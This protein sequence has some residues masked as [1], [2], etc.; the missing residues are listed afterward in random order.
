MQGNAINFCFKKQKKLSIFIIIANIKQLIFFK[1][2]QP[3]K[4]IIF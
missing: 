1:F 2:G 3:V 4:F